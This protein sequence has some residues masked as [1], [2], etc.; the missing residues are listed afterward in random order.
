M[1]L[2]L[3]SNSESKLPAGLVRRSTNDLF[4]VAEIGKVDDADEDD[5]DDDDD[6]DDDDDVDDDVTNPLLYNFDDA[7]GDWPWHVVFMIIVSVI[8]L[9]AF[10][11]ERIDQ[12]SAVRL[13][14]LPSPSVG[15]EPPPTIPTTIQLLLLVLLLLLL[16]AAAT[17][18][19]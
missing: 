17:A 2:S 12:L 5:V 16:L 6:D 18:R 14:L 13:P 9:V 4:S 3:S 19:L 10:F 1:T 8:C 7:K 11:M 15:H